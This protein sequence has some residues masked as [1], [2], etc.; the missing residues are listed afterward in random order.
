MLPHQWLPG[1]AA[2]AT[3]VLVDVRREGLK[4]SVVACHA[5]ITR[6]G[7]RTRNAKDCSTPV[8]I[9]HTYMIL[10]N[11]IR[12]EARPKLSLQLVPPHQQHSA[13]SML[14]DTVPEA[15]QQAI[16]RMCTA[17]PPAR[18][19]CS[20]ARKGAAACAAAVS[21]ATSSKRK[22]NDHQLGPTDWN[23]TA[24]AAP[25]ALQRGMKTATM[26]ISWAR[27]AS[28]HCPGQAAI[29]RHH[30]PSSSCC[31]TSGAAMPVRLCIWV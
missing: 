20:A 1:P 31:C 16:V 11:D 5:Q 14:K 23:T 9:Q 6:A 2:A 12:A 18:R 4:H 26:T 17:R 21:S 7:S 27:Q 13:P 8:T 25:S 3:G 10:Q 28:P 24:R 19:D 30:T 29:T 22:W 15:P